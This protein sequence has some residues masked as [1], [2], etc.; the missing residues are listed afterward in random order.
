MIMDNMILDKIR[1]ISFLTPTDGDLIAR[2]VHVKDGNI[3]TSAEKQEITDGTGASIA[4]IYNAK[5]ATVSA[6][7]ALFNKGLLALQLGAKEKQATSI[8]KVRMYDFVVATAKEGQITLEHEPIGLKSI[9][10]VE[11]NQTT[12]KFVVG[13]SA[14]A[15]NFSIEGSEITVPTGNS[16][17]KFYVEYEYDSETAIEI[18]NKSDQFPTNMKMRIYCRFRDVCDERKVQDLVIVS[19]RAKIDPSQV[20]IALGSVTD[21]HAFSVEMSKDICDETNDSLFTIVIDE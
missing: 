3:E 6:T 17:A 16:D 2:L 4:D 11:N 12:K 20:S 19:N 10:L 9:R 15:E 8:D 1:S 13:A 14:T 5:K 18:A 21:G 7:S